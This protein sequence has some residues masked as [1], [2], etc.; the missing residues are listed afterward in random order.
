[1]VIKLLFFFL[2]KDFLENNLRLMS[3]V[4]LV[5]P[6]GSKIQGILFFKIHNRIK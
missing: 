2:I 3:L 5:F 1:M 6:Q 4:I